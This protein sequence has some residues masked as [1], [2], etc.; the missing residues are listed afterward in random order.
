ML[1][2]NVSDCVIACLFCLRLFLWKSHSEYL[3]IR[4]DVVMMPFS[5]TLYVCMPTEYADGKD[6]EYKSH[7]IEKGLRK[8]NRFSLADLISCDNL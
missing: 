8:R 6:E 7:R 4:H 1:N 3:N 5:N 2:V